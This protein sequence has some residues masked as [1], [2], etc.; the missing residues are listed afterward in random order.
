MIMRKNVPIAEKERK[1]NSKPILIKAVDP[2]PGV[3]VE[4]DEAET[5]LPFL[6]KVAPLLGL[7]E[8]DAPSLQMLFSER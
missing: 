4:I 8:S 7:D 3:T 6:K 2:P 1:A 5:V